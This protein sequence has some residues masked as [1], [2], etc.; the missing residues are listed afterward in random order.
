MALRHRQPTAK[1]EKLEWVDEPGTDAAGIDMSA[2]TALVKAL[3]HLETVQ[4]A[5]YD[6]EIQPYTGLIHPRLT[7]AVKMG[8]GEPDRILR[9]GYP[10]SPG[11]IYA[12]LGTSPIGPV[13][14]LPAVSWDAFIQSGQRLPP[15]PN[16]VFAA[17]RPTQAR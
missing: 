13:V 4:Y 2:A 14:L 1:T 17:A 9:V 11:L 3:A 15:L 5:Q 16:D 8:Q 10:A 7:V 6:G 12:A